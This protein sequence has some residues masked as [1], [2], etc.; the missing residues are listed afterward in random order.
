[1]IN[2]HRLCFARSSIALYHTVDGWWIFFGW[3]NII[4]TFQLRASVLLLLVVVLLLLSSLFP[5]HAKFIYKNESLKSHRK[6]IDQHRVSECVYSFNIYRLCMVL[7]ATRI[8]ILLDNFHCC[9]FLF[10]FLF[11]AVEKNRGNSINPV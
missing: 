1:M 10:P 11:L 4:F 9:F 6:S 3:E 2:H 5:F 7:W 8:C